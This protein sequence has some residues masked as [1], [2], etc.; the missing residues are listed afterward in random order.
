MSTKKQKQAVA[1]APCPLRDAGILQ[2]VFA[3]LPGSWLFLGTVC[4]EW[5]AVYAGVGG[6]EVCSFDEY[7][8]KKLVNC[9]LKST[10]YSAAVGSPATARLACE[11]GLQISTTKN[12]LQ[13]IAGLHADIET[14]TVLRELGM[15]LSDTVVN[16]AALSGRVNVLQYLVKKQQCPVPEFLSQYAARSGNFSMVLSTFFTGEL[17]THPNRHL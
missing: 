11:G 14:L 7:G 3:F 15:P 4:S 1:A 12:S 16:A 2:H 6:Q 13:L 9:G 8:K 5:K 10:L 17:R